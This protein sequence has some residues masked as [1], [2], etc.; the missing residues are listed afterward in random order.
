M[1][2]PLDLRDPNAFRIAEVTE[3]L[4][5]VIDPE[6]GLDVVNMGL[7]YDI[8]CDAHRIQVIMTLTSRGCPMGQSIVGQAA[9]RLQEHFQDMDVH[10]HV[11]WEP[12]WTADRMS[13]EAKATLGWTR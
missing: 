4:R 12:K 8:R 3:L 11:V 13:P 9:E 5:Q 2:L 7:I 10:V 1:E 6:M